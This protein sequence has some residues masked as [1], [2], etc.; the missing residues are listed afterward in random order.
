MD[1]DERTWSEQV[2]DML[3][4]EG[5]AV[6]WLMDDTYGPLVIPTDVTARDYTTALVI[7]PG[8]DAGPCDVCGDP[9]EEHPS[10]IRLCTLDLDDPD[11]WEIIESV[12]VLSGIGYMG[13]ILEW[14]WHFSAVTGLV[15]DQE[16]ARANLAGQVSMLECECGAGPFTDQG[17]LDAH[18]AQWHEIEPGRRVV[19]HH[20]DTV[21]VTKIHTD[22]DRKPIQVR[23]DDGD[24]E[25]Y[26]RDQIARTIDAPKRLDTLDVYTLV[27][28]DARPEEAERGDFIQVQGVTL[29]DLHHPERWASDLAAVMAQR[30]AGR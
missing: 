8:Q 19:T 27:L 17:A 7:F 25:F 10:E 23:T 5:F 12:E 29:N 21:T 20:G 18:R 6:T 16:S 13:M 28:I 11:G 30:L 9:A 4:R 15:R 3:E 26:H 22:K 14:L 1:T 24:V 2:Y